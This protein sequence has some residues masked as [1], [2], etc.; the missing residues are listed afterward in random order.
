[1]VHL[2]PNL[3]VIYQK[4]TSTQYELISTSLPKG[5]MSGHEML[6]MTTMESISSILAYC[7]PNL[8][9]RDTFPHPHHHMG[10]A[11]TEYVDMNLTYNE[12]N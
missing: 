11:N 3:T 12:L 5:V 7:S 10:Y 4:K 9:D 1:M 8:E 6:Y 2:H